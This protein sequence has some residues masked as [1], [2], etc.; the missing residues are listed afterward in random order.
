MTRERRW[1]AAQEDKGEEGRESMTK[2][3]IDVDDKLLDRARRILGSAT[4]KDT[5]N[6]ALREIVRR[7][8]AEIFLSR[9]RDG[10]FGVA[11]AGPECRS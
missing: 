6:G 8:A 10:V 11:G 4:K 9:A 7:E 5:V 3:L 2:T 1:I